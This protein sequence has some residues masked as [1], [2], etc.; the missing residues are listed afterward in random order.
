MKNFSDTI[1]NRSR[2]VLV[3]STVPQPLAHHVPP[4]YD[5]VYVNSVTLTCMLH[6]LAC[7]YVI[8]RHVNAN[9]VQ[10]KLT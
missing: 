7:T 4:Y 10:R 3:C 5:T 2:D 9:I 6:V 1:G 8:L